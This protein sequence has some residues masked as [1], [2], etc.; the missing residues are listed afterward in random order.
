M[1]TTTPVASTPNRVRSK[2][3]NRHR[4]PSSSPHG[5]DELR[6]QQRRDRWS[7]RTETGHRDV[8][9]DQRAEP[10][11]Q[12]QR[13]YHRRNGRPESYRRRWTER[14]EHDPTPRPRRAVEEEDRRDRAQR[15]RELH[16]GDQRGVDLQRTLDPQH[17]QGEHERQHHEAGR[18][19]PD[20]CRRGADGLVFVEP[21]L[22]VRCH[23][24]R[25]P[26]VM[27]LVGDHH[28]ASPA[29]SASL[30]RRSR[31]VRSYLPVWEPGEVAVSAAT[32]RRARL[33]GRILGPGVANP[34]GRGPLRPSRPARPAPP[35]CRRRRARWPARRHASRP[36]SRSPPGSRAWRRA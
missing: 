2:G 24:V 11:H 26:L 7:D 9:P 14:A 13:Q 34:T 6:D 8:D 36:G 12:A 16:H 30:F 20:P 4:Q 35:R 33:S 3:W 23:G 15:R 10:H 18:G 21:A 22:C 32:P 19:R 1:P 27:V 25:P 5:P 28:T 29:S 31:L 17:G